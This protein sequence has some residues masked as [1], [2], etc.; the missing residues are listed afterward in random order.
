MKSY[1]EAQ[2]LQRVLQRMAG[3]VDNGITVEVGKRK[4]EWQF[5][6]RDKWGGDWWEE[7]WRK[8]RDFFWT[9]Y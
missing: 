4:G 1:A 7:N 2:S 5:H 9:G 8:V 3:T 6:I